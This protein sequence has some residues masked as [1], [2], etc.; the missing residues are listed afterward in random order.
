MKKMIVFY[1]LACICIVGCKKEEVYETGVIAGTIY[2]IEGDCFPGPQSECD[3]TTNLYPTT[4]VISKPTL[5]YNENEVVSK[6]ETDNNAF[7][8]DTLPVGEY[9]VFI[10][11]KKENTYVCFDNCTPLLVKPNTKITIEGEIYRVTQ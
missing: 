7:F 6:I 5:T 9:T 11:Y 3:I 10:L 8:R 1:T 4:V 2:L